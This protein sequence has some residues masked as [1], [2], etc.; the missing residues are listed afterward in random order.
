LDD[1]KVHRSI[2]MAQEYGV[3]ASRGDLENR[4]SPANVANKLSE[5]D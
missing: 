2:F 3:A 1:G 4:E 5:I